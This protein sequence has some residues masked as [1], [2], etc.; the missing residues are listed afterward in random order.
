[1]KNQGNQEKLK[2]ISLDEIEKKRDEIIE[3]GKTIYRNPETGYKE[4]NTSAM[5]EELFKSHGVPFRKK[6]AITGIIG[7]MDTGKPGPTV[8][9]LSELD[10]L[11][12]AKH[13]DAD[14]RTGAAH[15]CGH[16]AQVSWITGALIGLK[17]V[18]GQLSGRI[19]LMAIPAEEF[20]E[21]DYRG[22]L[23]NEGKIRFYGGKQEFIRLGLF[24]DVDIAIM[25]HAH[26]D[27]P[28][29]SIQIPHCSNG[30][31]GKSIRFIGRASHAGAAPHL[32]INAINMFHVALSAINAQRETFRDS[33][34][35]RVHMIVTKGGES[36][37][38]IP[39]E[40]DVEMYVRGKSLEA[41]RNAGEKVDNAL[42]AGALGMGGK[43]EIKNIPGY[44]PLKP[45]ESLHRL[46]E[47][48]ASQLLG[49]SMIFHRES[50]GAST[51]MGDVSHLIP[52]IEPSS[53]GFTGGLHSKDFTVTDE[54]MAYI[55][56]AKL[57][58][59]T[60]IDL[61][62]GNAETAKK[63]IAGHKPIFDR[64]EYIQRMNSL[65]YQTG[66]P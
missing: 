65:F 28:A 41:I 59:M 58:A 33:D 55:V 31:V 36:V 27:S 37:N 32:G 25:N 20:I 26:S 45:D 5:V 21:I 43:V 56:P 24:D 6:L 9:I 17:P 40:V 57:Y 52:A 23:R 10:A 62:S 16:F 48:N 7:E 60:V 11:I 15:A 39:D 51:D 66:W 2:R 38:V 1:L 61:L 19:L 53:G 29:R 47:D 64:E 44:L 13:P 42:K 30:F 50:I 14:S 4:F 34:S 63:V 35:I 46:W 8:A 22:K 12:N 54:E 49:E 18:L 3:T